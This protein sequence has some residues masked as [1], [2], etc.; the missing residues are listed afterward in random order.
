MVSLLDS[1]GQERHYATIDLCCICTNLPNNDF[2]I[3]LLAPLKQAFSV[4]SMRREGRGNLDT[5]D[6]VTTILPSDPQGIHSPSLLEFAEQHKTN[7]LDFSSNHAVQE[8]PPVKNIK[9]GVELRHAGEYQKKL[10]KQRPQDANHTCTVRTI[11]MYQQLPHSVTIYIS[12][13]STT[14]PEN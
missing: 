5:H 8:S 14:L 4:S 1:G 12:H 11:S 6:P 13:Q 3:I 10:S 2:L 7:L 9:Q